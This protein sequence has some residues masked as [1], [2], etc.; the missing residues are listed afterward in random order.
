MR[1]LGATL[2]STGSSLHYK[3]RI[4]AQLYVSLV[5]ASSRRSNSLSN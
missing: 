5:S 1:M 3:V 2:H 4:V